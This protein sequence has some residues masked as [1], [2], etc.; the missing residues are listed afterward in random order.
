MPRTKKN[1]I[2]LISIIDGSYVIAPQIFATCR[3]ETIQALI[4]DLGR[5]EP[6]RQYKKR[7]KNESK[8]EESKAEEQK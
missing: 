8:K 6:K 1:C 2:H 7:M 4:A 3:S 5:E